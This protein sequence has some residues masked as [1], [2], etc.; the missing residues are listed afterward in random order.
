M[1]AVLLDGASL[2]TVSRPL[3]IL[4]VFTGV[5]LPFSVFVFSWVLRRTKVTGTLTHS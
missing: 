3:L 2:A 4:L 1:R 5:L